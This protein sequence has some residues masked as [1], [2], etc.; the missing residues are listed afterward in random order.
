LFFS[1]CLERQGYRSGLGRSRGGMQVLSRLGLIRR[2]PCW[3]LS[4][5]GWVLLLLL[6]A[7]WLSAGVAGIHPFLAVSQP[8][9]GDI[10]VVEGWLPDYALHQA[11]ETFQ[12]GGYRYL[13]TTGGPLETGSYL[14][15]YTTY[16]ELA[17]ASLL[18]L[19]LDAEKIAAVPASDV[20]KDRTYYSALALRAWLFQNDAA[21]R[22]LDIFT[23]GV[24]ARR[25]RR[26]F[27]VALGPDFSVGVMAAVDRNYDPKRWWASSAGAKSVLSETISYVYIRIFPPGNISFSGR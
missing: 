6:T 24:H 14:V 5:R 23:L 2:T 16:A 7:L 1:R 8:V 15:A 21:L 12:S 11:L 20:P 27:Q 22:A 3:G 25:T 10:L 18:A 9:S 19:G 26:L 17:A 4:L 13:I